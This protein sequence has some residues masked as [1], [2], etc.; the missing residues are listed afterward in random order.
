M[1]EGV[2]GGN[3]EPG[4]AARLEHRG[5]SV[6]GEGHAR[7]AG[8]ESHVDAVAHE[9]LPGDRGAEV[10]LVLMIGIDHLDLFVDL[11]LSDGREQ[12]R[13]GRKPGDDDRYP[14]RSL[15]FDPLRTLG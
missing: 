14:R 7:G 4:V 15:L 9:P 11:R 3:Q 5:P 2:I 8:V 12:Q 13:R 10:R 6:V 1:A